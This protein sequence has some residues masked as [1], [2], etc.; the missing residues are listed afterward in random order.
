MNRYLT[1]IAQIK[2]KES[3]KGELHADLGIPKGEKIPASKLSAAKKS[4]KASGNVAEE[5][6]IVFAENAKKWSKK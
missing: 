6:R 4:A 2:I 1:K 5:K 3:H